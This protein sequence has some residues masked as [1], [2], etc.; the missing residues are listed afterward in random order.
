MNPSINYL[1]ILSI[2]IYSMFFSVVKSHSNIHQQPSGSRIGSHGMVLF[3]NGKSLFASHMPL[4]NKPHDYQ[5]IYKV[6]SNFKNTIID[7]LKA[8][9]TSNKAEPL[10]SILPQRFD[11]NVLIE[12][13]PLNIRADV[14]MGH[15]ERGGDIWLKDAQFKFTELIFKKQIINNNIDAKRSLWQQLNIGLGQDKLYVHI[16]KSAPSFDAI[17]LASDCGSIMKTDFYETKFIKNPPILPESV[18]CKKQT[19]LYYET[20]DFM[21]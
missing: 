17:I 10:I 18:N 11:L 6:E 1:L 12:N 5:L 14:Y 16:I 7:N 15:F 4:Y 21:E 20:Q 3:T 9:L 19:I 8:K 2:S 13:K